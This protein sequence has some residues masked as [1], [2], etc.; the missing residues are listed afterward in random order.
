MTPEIAGGR[1]GG[2]GRPPSSLRHHHRGGPRGRAHGLTGSV[3][4]EAPI[5]APSAR[6]AYHEMM[7][8]LRP[9]LDW[10]T[11]QAQR[12]GLGD[13]PRFTDTGGLMGQV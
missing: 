2:D 7:G 6:G 8:A 1:Q 11:S 4:V 5:G 13:A 10:E 9:L 12:W 3:I